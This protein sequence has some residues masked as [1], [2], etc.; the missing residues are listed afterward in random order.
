MDALAGRP[1]CGASDLAEVGPGRG[2][3]SSAML[4]GTPIGAGVGTP[5]SGCGSEGGADMAAMGAAGLFAS[6]E[7]AAGAERAHPLKRTTATT[8]PVVRSMAHQRAGP[9]ASYSTR[10]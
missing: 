10:G 3:V 4:D 9:D 1:T 2:R 8:K 5:G 6:K 7:T